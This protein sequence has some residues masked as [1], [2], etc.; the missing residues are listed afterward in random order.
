MRVSELR[1]L[2]WCQVDLLDRSVIVGASKT[3]GG[4]GRVIPLNQEAYETVTRW[5]SNFENPLPEHYVFPSEG[6]GFDG[7]NSHKTGAVAVWDS[8]PTTPMGSWNVA[9]SACRRST[10]VRCRLL[11]L[12]HTFVSRL[13]E[14]KVAD[15]TLTALSG[16]MSR[17]MLERYSHTRNE[18]KR[19]AVELLSEPEIQ[20][21]SPQKSPQ[22]ER[23]TITS[24]Q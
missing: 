5:R 2:K 15:S 18:A 19:K 8:N 1:L 22:Q 24:I 9:W 16:W 14:K 23:A 20:E 6:Y 7:H 10:G 17:K 3:E 13:G 21:E 4:K 12:R 11:D